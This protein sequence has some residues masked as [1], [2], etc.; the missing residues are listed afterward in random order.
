MSGLS[1]AN[2]AKLLNG[3]IHSSVDLL[4]IIPRRI[5][6]VNDKEV[7]RVPEEPCAR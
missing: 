5:L 4:V 1:I 7:C 6:T 2:L 3:S